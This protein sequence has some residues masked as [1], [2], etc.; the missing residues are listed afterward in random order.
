MLKNLGRRFQKY[1]N[2]GQ[3]ELADGWK[4][5][6]NQRTTMTE[7]LDWMMST[8]VSSKLPELFWASTDLWLA[9]WYP[10]AITTMPYAAILFGHREEQMLPA[11]REH[12]LKEQFQTGYHVPMFPFMQNQNYWDIFR[13]TSIAFAYTI[14]ESCGKELE[15][16]TKEAGD[17][18]LSGRNKSWSRRFQEFWSNHGGV[19]M[20][21]LSGMKDPMLNLMI[22][23]PTLFDELLEHQPAAKKAEYRMLRENKWVIKA[24]YD[25]LEKTFADSTQHTT[26]E[27]NKGFYGGDHFRFRDSFDSGMP[28]GWIGWDNY[29]DPNLEPEFWNG[30]NSKKW[31][32]VFNEIRGFLYALPKL[33]TKMAEQ[34]GY[35]NDKS[36]INKITRSLYEKNIAQMRDGMEKKID[37]SVPKAEYCSMTAVMFELVQPKLLKWPGDGQNEQNRYAKY[38]EQM[39]ACLK[40]AKSIEDTE[41][42]P[43]AIAY[44][45]KMADIWSDI[46]KKQAPTQTLTIEQLKN[47]AYDSDISQIKEK[48]Q[49]RSGTVLRGKLETFDAIARTGENVLPLDKGGAAANNELG[50]SA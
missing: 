39:R 38:L 5:N 22:N 45:E 18:R 8:A 21:K 2:N 26:M 30:G 42:F 11:T 23:D 50:L 32:G 47:G 16:L 6:L 27:R 24:Y 4:G 1:M 36:I 43:A 15:K 34:M 17:N 13:D 35:P 25:R 41:G 40:K 12:I 14:S 37:A 20:N 46:I 10:T 31:D 28:I 33:A 9:E 44:R 29:L 19:L 7:K 48:T 3:Q 49:S